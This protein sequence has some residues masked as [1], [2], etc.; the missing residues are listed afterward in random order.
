MPK[1]DVPL[2]PYVPYGTFQNQTR[3]LGEKGV[4]SRIDNSVL[5]HLAGSIQSQLLSAWRFFDL[6]DSDGKPSQTLKDLIV[7]TDDG[8]NT[9]MSELIQK[10]YSAEQL[11][12]L[13]N[14]SPNSFAEKFGGA[15]SVREKSCR[16]LI[17]AAQ[18]CGLQ[19]SKYLVSDSGRL[20]G[21]DSQR[22]TKKRP[23]K[24][25]SPEPQLQAEEPAHQA[26][27]SLEPPNNSAKRY[28]FQLPRGRSAE[29]AWPADITPIEIKALF[30][31]LN[32]LRSMLEAEASFRDKT[33]DEEE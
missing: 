21:F 8:W 2:C 6:I 16:F 3:A 4:P 18:G 5:V 28:Q 27:V 26:A 24:N 29:L 32:G 25:G 10:H 33:D 20:K 12:E 1:T 11:Q 23:K 19:V 17:T 14:G 9:Y 15:G 22:S 31:Q 30:A 7:S 13:R